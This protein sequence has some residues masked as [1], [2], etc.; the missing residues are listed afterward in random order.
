MK[1]RPHVALSCDIFQFWLDVKNTKTD[2]H[3]LATTMLAVPASQISVE[4]AVS[5]LALVLSNGRSHLKAD[6][7]QNLLLIKLNFGLLDEI[8]K[9][10]Y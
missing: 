8:K 10:R 2:L 4:R 7:L 5:A 3:K 1:S 9:C 6:N